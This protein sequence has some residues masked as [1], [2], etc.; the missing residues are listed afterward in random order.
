[1]PYNCWMVGIRGFDFWHL[2]LSLCWIHWAPMTWP[3]FGLSSWAGLLHGVTSGRW[4]L[5]ML[6]FAIKGVYNDP[7]FIR[8]IV[9][10]KGV[11]I[12]SYQ[13][14]SRRVMSEQTAWLMTSMLRTAEFP[15]P[16]PRGQVPGCIYSGQNRLPTTI[17]IHGSAALPPDLCGS[18][19][20]GV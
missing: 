11:K 15:V 6:A 10:C 8:R 16:V 20:A 2:W 5:H 18:G 3:Y 19:L 17:G 1:M 7:H 14:N 9:D 13:P 12:Y 4:R